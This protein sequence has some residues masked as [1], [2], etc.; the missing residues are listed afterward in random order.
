MYD[1][2]RHIRK[3]KFYALKGFE[4]LAFSVIAIGFL[5]WGLSVM[6]GASVLK[7]LV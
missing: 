7:I 3:E 1:E 4:M 5:I 2:R 6:C